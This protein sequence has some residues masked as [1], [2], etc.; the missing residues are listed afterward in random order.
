MVQAVHPY[1]DLAQAAAFSK[2]APKRDS[3]FELRYFGLHGFGATCRA[4]LAISGANVKNVV[5]A[6]WAAEK[7]DAPFGVMPLLKEISA[8]GK[9]IINI[10]ESD[11]IE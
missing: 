8:D 7:P 10:A 11:A 1:F 6:D 2:L 5:P 9:T 3:S 4:L